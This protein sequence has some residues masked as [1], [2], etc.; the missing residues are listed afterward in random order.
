MT[1]NSFAYELNNVL[2]MYSKY[3]SNIFIKFYLLWLLL[4]KIFKSVM[5]N[6]RSDKDHID[7]TALTAVYLSDW[8]SDH[9]MWYIINM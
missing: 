8:E 6:N 2:I 7:W 3:I 9:W 1:L 4:L 5:F